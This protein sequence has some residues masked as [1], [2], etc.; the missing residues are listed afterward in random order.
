M[1][2]TDTVISATR[3]SGRV[4]GWVRPKTAF[5]AVVLVVFAV[6]TEMAFGLE[7]LTQAGRIGPGFFPRIVGVGGVVIT[8]WAL[9]TAIRSPQEEDEVVGLE[10]EFGEADLGTHPRLLMIM[11]LAAGVFA[12]ALVSLG[13]IISSAV[14][15]AV[16]LSL[17]NRGRHQANAIIAIVIPLA[18]YLLLQTLL[19]AGLPEGILP[20]F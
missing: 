9:V 16:M 7:W 2:L 5:L 1:T 19:N 20:R 12:A 8:L 4:A 17:L 6:Y 15:L 13:A 3:P 14:F 18:M 11:V 10:D